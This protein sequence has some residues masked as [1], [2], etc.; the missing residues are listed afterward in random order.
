MTAC[1]NSVLHP[2]LKGELAAILAAMPEPPA[3]PTTGWR[4]AWERW[5]E[6]LAIKPTLL[7]ELPPLRI[8]PVGSV[9][10]TV[11]N[12]FGSGIGR[13]RSI[14]PSAMLNIAALA[15]T[16]IAMDR[17]ATSENPGF[18]A[19][20]CVP[21]RRSCQNVSSIAGPFRPP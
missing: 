4:A 16:P 18:F 21:C 12:P 9:A 19:S 3:E 20:I 10:L 11:S 15:P 8:S 2:W 5:R 6:G 7:D 1:P 17:M 14:K 13:G